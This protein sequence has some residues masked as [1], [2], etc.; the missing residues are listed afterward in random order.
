MPLRL[1]IACASGSI[2]T[3]TT[4][5][6]TMTLTPA[7]RKARNSA[8]IARS[9]FGAGLVLSLAANVWASAG[10]GAIGVVSG[11][12]SP[13]AL[14]VSLALIESVKARGIAGISRIVGVA[15]LAAIAAWVSYWHLVDFF[16]TGGITEPGAHLMPLTVDVLMAL[17]SP[18]MKRKASP[19]P[20][21]RRSRAKNVTPITR[22]KKTA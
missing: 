21:A 17:A 5:G 13:L 4:K 7:A 15:V 12:W 18:S 11:L 16:L 6:N 8:Y 10:H 19:A 14:L 22:A 20:S 2:L 3:T 9:A 1:R